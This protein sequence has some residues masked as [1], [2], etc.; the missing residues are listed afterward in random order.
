M[1]LVYLDES[2]N[3]GTNLS[4]PQQPVFVLAALI[5]PESVWLDLEKRLVEAIE[6]FFPERPPDFEVHA[7]QLLNPRGF[8]RAFPM[9]HRLEFYRTWLSIAASLRL[10]LVSRAIVKKRYAQWLLETYGPGVAINPH[11]VA[12]VLTAQ[13]VNEFLRATPGSPLGILIS[14]ENHEVM[15]DIEK[16]IRLLRGEAGSLRLSQ[17]VEKGFFIESRKSHIL[18]LCDLC[19]YAIRRSEEQKTGHAVKP[20][21]LSIIPWVEPLRHT[22]E[23]PM[24]DVLAWL[25]TQ[26]KK[27]RPGR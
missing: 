23:E 20:A 13:V 12:F 19:A 6:N 25:D 16:S 7:N 15:P 27:E 24:V 22:A 1:N 14:D 10:R 4:D 3:T 9:A 11:N 21:E 2:G 26:R 5:V 8:F 18:Q 17:I